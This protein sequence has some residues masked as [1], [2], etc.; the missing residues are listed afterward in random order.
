[1]MASPVFVTECLGG[2]PAAYIDNGTN[3]DFTTPYRQ[4]QEN[5]Q[6]HSVGKGIK[7]PHPGLADPS[8]T[9]AA[10]PALHPSRI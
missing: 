5:L 4:S 9:A 7:D 2:D 1:M 10:A 8:P 6:T 3:C